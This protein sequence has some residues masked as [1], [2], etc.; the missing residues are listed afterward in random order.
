MEN[1]NITSIRKQIE[2]SITKLMFSIISGATDDDKEFSF[3][4]TEDLKQVD[5]V[6]FYNNTSF[7]V[8]F[9]GMM[10]ILTK[11][12]TVNNCDMKIVVRSYEKDFIIGYLT[13]SI[14][15]DLTSVIHDMSEINTLRAR[16]DESIKN[17]VK[18]ARKI[19]D[20]SLDSGHQFFMTRKEIVLSK[21]GIENHNSINNGYWESY[22]IRYIVKIVKDESMTFYM[23]RDHENGCMDEILELDD[24]REVILN[25]ICKIPLIES[26]MMWI[27]FDGGSPIEL[28]NNFKESCS[29]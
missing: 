14:L 28:T 10:P 21:Y 16:L 3:T 25:E 11:V 20:D 27:M 17:E 1:P 26:T 23:A 12:H 8:D 4:I 19:F 5:L 9:G 2:S 15:D 24:N 22:M 7:K 29:N 18:L 13:S 6:S